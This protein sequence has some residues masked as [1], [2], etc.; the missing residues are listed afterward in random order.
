MNTNNMYHLKG[1]YTV[2]PYYGPETVIGFECNYFARNNRIVAFSN[3]Q[4]F[5]IRAPEAKIV[6]DTKEYRIEFGCSACPDL[7]PWKIFADEMNKGNWSAELPSSCV[8]LERGEVVYGPP[9]ARESYEASD[10]VQIKLRS[11][12]SVWIEASQLE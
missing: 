9:L 2:V 11:G 8:W 10:F 6:S 12:T 5:T 7:E 1:N 3:R 4:P